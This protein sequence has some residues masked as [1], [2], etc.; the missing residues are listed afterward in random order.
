LHLQPAPIRIASA[1]FFYREPD[2]YKKLFREI[3]TILRSL[4]DTKGRSEILRQTLHAIIESCSE[5]YGI[6]SGRLYREQGGYFVLIESVGG[7][8]DKI[9]GMKVDSDY[10]MIQCLE[11]ERVIIITPETPGFDP[12]IEYQFTSHSYAAMMLGGP[13]RYI[14]SFGIRRDDDSDGH[15]HFILESI[16]SSVGLKI[17]QGDLENQMRQARQIQMSLL[18]RTLPDLP[19]F[20][21]AARSI[22]A[23]DVGGDIY[24]CQPIDEGIVGILMADASGHGLPAAL[25]ARDVITGLRMGV[26]QNQKISTTIEKLNS[27]INQSGLVSRFVS[28]FY[29]EL[30]ES[31][32]LVFINGGHC[33]PLLFCTDDKI[34]ELPSNGP[35]LGPLP[36]ATYRRSY[37]SLYPGE[38]LVL[39]SDGIIERL[40]EAD[41]D[42]ESKDFGK[43][44]LIKVINACRDKPAEEM[45]DIVFKT[46]VEFGDHTP[47]ADDASI[48]I[49]KR[50]PADLYRP[51]S[52]L[53]RVTPV[54]SGERID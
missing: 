36:D 42:D 34:F 15:L 51:K 3:E 25:Q 10:P 22:P 26:A 14:M 18:P 23:E 2:L 28:V 46:V 16:R 9:K 20:D 1:L 44:G 12:A 38:V 50:L 53:G 7:F 11:R 35:V 47:W 5:E 17:R 54:I 48:M 13:T 4:D 29:G 6:D 24:D 45:V 40:P 8:G 43:A 39:F 49:V 27:V 19:G 37:A 41:E 33:P 31:G 52:S 32:S 30:E 21:I